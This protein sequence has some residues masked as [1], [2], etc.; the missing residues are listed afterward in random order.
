MIQLTVLDRAKSVAFQKGQLE[1]RLALETAYETA[2][3]DILFNGPRSAFARMPAETVYTLNAKTV[4]VSVSAESGRI[5]VNKAD[6]ALIDRALMG[7]GIGSSQRAAFTGR[8]TQ[9]RQ[10]GSEIATMADLGDI[11]RKARMDANG[12]ICVAQYLTVYSGLPRP[13]AGHMPG[14]LMRAIGEPNLSTSAGFQPGSALRIA[15]AAPGGPPLVA[16]VRITA[17]LDRAVDA[18]DWHKA[19]GCTKP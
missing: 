1:H 8:L 13:L 7:L 14:E 5:D 18:L 10:S 4:K 2:V 16:V 12:G 17:R 6:L 15:I 3:A 9:Q 11:L 19:A